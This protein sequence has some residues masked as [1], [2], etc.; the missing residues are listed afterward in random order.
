MQ[1]FKK[2]TAAAALQGKRINSQVEEQ[3]SSALEE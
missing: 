1:D 2:T 3:E